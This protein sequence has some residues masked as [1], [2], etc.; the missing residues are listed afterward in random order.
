MRLLLCSTAKLAHMHDFLMA[1]YDIP[2]TMHSLSALFRRVVFVTPLLLGRFVRT[3]QAF[4]VVG[5][6]RTQLNMPTQEY[7]T[8]QVDVKNLSLHSQQ[9]TTQTVVAVVASLRAVVFRLT[10]R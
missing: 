2:P 9:Q 3:V 8:D 1:H 7:K 4:M 10:A 5:G 6:H